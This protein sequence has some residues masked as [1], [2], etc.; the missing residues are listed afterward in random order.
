MPE[1]YMIIARKIF[2]P[3]FVGRARAP[4]PPPRLLSLCICS[5]LATPLAPNTI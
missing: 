2:L 3:N 5:I 1:F 4:L